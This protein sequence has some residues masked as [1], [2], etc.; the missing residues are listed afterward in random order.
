MKK[1]AKLFSIDPDN[2]TVSDAYILMPTYRSRG[3][4]AQVAFFFGDGSY[5]EYYRPVIK[6]NEDNTYNVA[7]QDATE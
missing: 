5:K 6:K 7:I 3:H 2:F 4:D 1:V